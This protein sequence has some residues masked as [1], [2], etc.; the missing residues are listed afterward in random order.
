MNKEILL[1]KLFLVLTA[2]VA[3]ETATAKRSRRL[4]KGDAQ[5][6]RTLRRLSGK[7]KKGGGD[8]N[9][10]AIVPRPTP[11][12]IP[13]PS[14]PP[15]LPSAPR[16]TRAPTPAPVASPTPQQ[17]VV[18]LLFQCGQKV[19]FPVKRNATAFR[20]DYEMNKTNGSVNVSYFLYRVAGSI[21]FFYEGRRVAATRNIPASASTQSIPVS[22]NGS[23]SKVEVLV[24]IAQQQDT[25]QGYWILRMGCF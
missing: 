13:R 1:S 25:S 22:I 2:M 21:T 10:G 11:V 17:P 4:S 14:L 18:P 24:E 12:A 5:S 19:E 15:A 9:D 16:R 6:N 23:S 20:F 7:G 3:L 8:D